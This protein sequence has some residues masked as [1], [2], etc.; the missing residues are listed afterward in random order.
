MVGLG[1]LQSSWCRFAVLGLEMPA[2][3]DMKRAAHK[4]LDRRR[5]EFCWRGASSR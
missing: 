1:H 5:G 2:A 4:I 3:L